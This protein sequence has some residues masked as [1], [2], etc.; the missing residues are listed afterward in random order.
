MCL[1]H[2][3]RR[4]EDGSLARAMGNGIAFFGQLDGHLANKIRPASIRLVKYVYI[5]RYHI[6]F[7]I[8]QSTKRVP[9]PENHAFTHYI[10][11]YIYQRKTGCLRLS[12]FTVD[13]DPL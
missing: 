11:I 2:C 3:G 7:F 12:E 9:L 5:Y 13:M 1:C 6:Y 10:Y 8:P 4:G